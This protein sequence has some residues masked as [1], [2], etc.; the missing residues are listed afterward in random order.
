MTESLLTPGQINLITGDKRAIETELLKHFD[1]DQL[2][3][4]HG[5]TSRFQYSYPP[6][7]DACDLPDAQDTAMEA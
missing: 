7:V 4:E 5:G 2:L 1:A 3:E 6:Y